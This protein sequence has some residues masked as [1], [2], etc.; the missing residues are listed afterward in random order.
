MRNPKSYSVEEVFNNAELDFVFEFYTS[1]KLD[2]II[3]D[4]SGILGKQ[5]VVTI[6]ESHKPSWSTSI[7]LEEYKAARSKYSLK[8]GPQ[9][10]SNIKPNLRILLMWIN[11]NAV[12][13]HS[14]GLGVNLSFNHQ[15]LQ[16]LTHISNMNIGKMILK[17]NE[18]YIYEK[19]GE[20][21]DNAH[22]MSI[23]KV[24]PLS[25][26]I[27]ASGVIHNMSTVFQLPIS[28]H[29]GIDFTD[30]THGSIGFNYIRGSKYS[31][32]PNE[33]EELLE[34][35][36]LTAYQTLNEVDYTEFEE[37]EL[38]KM[39]E[40]YLTLK[41]SWHDSNKFIRE[42]KKLK[43]MVDLNTNPGVIQTHWEKIRKPLF[44]ILF[45]SGMVEGKFNWDSDEGMFQFKDA[46]IKNAFISNMEFVNC[47]LTNCV[48][49]NTMFWASK[50]S[51][52]ILT[53]SVLVSKNKVSRCD[54]NMVR[55][56]RINKI[57]ES[58]IKNNG[59]IINCKVFNTTVKNAGL[60][61]NAKL[62]E[63]SVIIETRSF[64]PQM[65]SGIESSETR[66]YKWLKTLRSNDYDDEKGFENE[67]KT[68][69]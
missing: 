27:N 34:Y 40:N 69:Y 65:T 48:F 26:F 13:D 22:C 59:E 63:S 16:T 20:A 51:N 53:K 5:L 15:K 31:D 6:D 17:I 42:N 68:D 45:E 52:S 64:Q 38:A 62:D 3:K 67:F 41:N 19:F 33:I 61:K 39:T 21:K 44:E 50:I 37:N 12:L 23:K 46:K 57:D 35:Y 66:D 47:T 25:N 9:Q 49:E 4:I 29:Y 28:E 60:G 24:I 43:I 14:T 32:K 7:L 36:I 54:M 58:F 18:N 2:F 10:F 56:D 1:K 30:Y 11:E 55:A 8:V